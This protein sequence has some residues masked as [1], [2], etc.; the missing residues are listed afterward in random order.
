MTLVAGWRTGCRGPRPAVG[1][2]VSD[3]TGHGHAASPARPLRV[4]I[5]RPE[6]GSHSLTVPSLPQVAR[7][8]PSPFQATPVTASRWPRRLQGLPGGE[9]PYPGSAV[10]APRCQAIRYRKGGKG[11][12]DVGMALEFGR[13]GPMPAAID[14]QLLAVGAHGGV[15]AGIGVRA[16]ARAY[17]PCKGI[18]GWPRSGFR[19][20]NRSHF[21]PSAAHAHLPIRPRGVESRRGC[22]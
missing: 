13:R 19:T 7:R 17:G 2:S 5:S 22:K 4:R 20:R 10:P 9:G 11:Q 6:A 12:H 8:V 3:C 16:A 14:Q 18:P 15:A 21:S 1:A